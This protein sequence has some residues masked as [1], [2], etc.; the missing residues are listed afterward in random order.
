MHP[1]LICFTGIDGCGKSTQVRKL[2]EHLRAEGL[3]T[4]TVWSGGRPYISR[5]VVRLVKRLLRAPKQAHDGQFRA[6]DVDGAPVASEFSDYLQASNRMFKRSW[7]LRRGWTD[8]SLLE[9]AIEAIVTVIPHLYKGRTVVC[10]RYLFKSIVNLAV[11]FDLPPGRL[12]QLLRHPMLKIVPQP[13][14][15]FLLDVPAEVGYSRKHDLPSLE[16]VARRVP[17][18]RELADLTGM[19]VVDATQTPDQVHEQVW[20]IVASKLTSG[21]WLP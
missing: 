20:N 5:P 11:L 15:Y 19:P 6:R 2:A 9:H 1:P 3:E 21:G 4:V 17:I 8:V 10:D 14:L 7:I 18:Y 12:P 13:T 16:Y